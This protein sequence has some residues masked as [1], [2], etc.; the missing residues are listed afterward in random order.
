MFHFF[1]DT[2]SPP[3]PPQKKKQQQKNKNNNNKQTKKPHTLHAILFSG[4]TQS[5]RTYPASIRSRPLL[6]GQLIAI[7]M[8]FRWRAD[9]G[10]IL[11]A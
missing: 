5:N 8:A 2:P 6:V 11:H 1:P 10:P 4:Y 7:R 9:S 3:P